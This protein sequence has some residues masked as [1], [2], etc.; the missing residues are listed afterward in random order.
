[1]ASVVYSCL[2]HGLAIDQR[3]NR[4]S[5]FDIIENVRTSISVLKSQSDANGEKIPKE[6][7]WILSQVKASIITQ[8][9]RSQLKDPEEAK[10]RIRI[11]SDDGQTFNSDIDV[12]VD[13]KTSISNR[14]I[15]DL[16]TVPLCFRVGD[17]YQFFVVEFLQNEEWVEAYRTPLIVRFV[18]D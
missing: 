4:V 7:D 5:I 17:H 16:E 10:A 15:H 13:L 1:M 2:C 9:S 6:G 11:V 3:S 18:E 12:E 14:I 8:F